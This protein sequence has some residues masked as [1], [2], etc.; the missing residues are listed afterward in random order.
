MDDCTT[1][2]PSDDIRLH[3]DTTSVEAQDY[4]GR[5]RCARLTVPVLDMIYPRE[6]V[7]NVAATKG[8]RLQVFIT[9]PFPYLISFIFIQQAGDTLFPFENFFDIVLS[10]EHSL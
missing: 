7:G 8:E 6:I 3:V 5:K 10:L 1:A 4:E 2:Y 9:R